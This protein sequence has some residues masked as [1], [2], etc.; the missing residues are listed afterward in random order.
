[1]STHSVAQ[2][3]QD[4]IQGIIDNRLARHP[5]QT[6]RSVPELIVDYIESSLDDLTPDDIFSEDDL[7]Q[8]AE[9]NG[10]EKKVEP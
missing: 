3:I 1:M 8:W 9:D 6:N 4:G 7:T 10:F 5:Y 2:D